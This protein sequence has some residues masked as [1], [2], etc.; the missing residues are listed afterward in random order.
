MTTFSCIFIWAA[1][2]VV[3]PILVIWHFTK[4]KNQ[5]VRE[6]RNRGWTWKRIAAKYGVS[7]STVRRWSMA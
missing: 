4:S 2:L 5:R 6:M 3:L 7:Q 1:M